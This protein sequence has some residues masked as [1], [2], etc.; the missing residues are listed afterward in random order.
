[1]SDALERIVSA[2]ETQLDILEDAARRPNVDLTKLSQQSLE[3]LILAIASAAATDK[4]FIRLAE[5]VDRW[6]SR[7]ADVHHHLIELSA[8]WRCP[9]CKS[10]VAREAAIDGVKVGLP[11]VE[12]ICANC[13]K[14]SRL[15]AKGQVAFE[16]IF[17]PLLSP[18][19]NPTLNGFK[20]NE[21]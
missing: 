15:N 6:R 13:G 3:L 7:G 16:R 21:R 12:L 2:T 9:A 19:W 1:M 20:W 17:G 4:R 18:D 11:R 14:K 5:R 10:D 8:D